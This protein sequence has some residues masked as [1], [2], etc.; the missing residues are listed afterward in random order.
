M[1]TRIPVSV[2]SLVLLGIVSLPAADWIRQ[3][4]ALELQAGDDVGANAV[5]AI[6]AGD[7]APWLRGRAL[8][9]LA[10]HAPDRIGKEL[11]A[12]ATSADPALR[13]A[14]A[15]ACVILGTRQARDLATDLLADKDEA[16]RYAAA[17][18]VAKHEG[19]GAWRALRPTVEKLIP[20]RAEIQGRILCAVGSSAAASRFDDFYTT[21][22]APVKRDLVRSLALAQ[23]ERWMLR[24]ERFL[25]DEDGAIRSVARTAALGLSDDAYAALLARCTQPSADSLHMTAMLLMLERPD[26]QGTAA[27]AR[28]LEIGIKD[29]NVARH[30]I[31]LLRVQV[32][33]SF[34]AVVE[35]YVVADDRLVRMSAVRLL[36]GFD[37]PERGLEIL[38]PAISD[39]H[40]DVVREAVRIIR[41]EFD[42]VPSGG[43]VPYVAPLLER[44]NT[45]FLLQG[46][47]L[48]RG[49]LSEE[50]ID[51]GIALLRPLLNSENKYVRAESRATLA[52][53]GQGGQSWRVAALTGFM[54]RW[55][56]IGP[57]ENDQENAGFR[58]SHP[59]EDRVDLTATYP[60][61][62]RWAAANMP[63]LSWSE[64]ITGSSG[65]LRL[66]NIFPPPVEFAT[67]Y[68]YTEFA[69]DMEREVVME[70][71][72]DDAVAVWLNGQRVITEGADSVAQ[73]MD[74]SRRDR[75][76]WWDGESKK[77]GS[78]YPA[79]TGKATVTL[80]QGR[81]TIL[82]K[83]SNLDIYWWL[84][85]RL[86]DQ[87][88]KAV[89][90]EW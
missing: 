42:A 53:A 35:R 81:N 37:D 56:V 28:L 86:M 10:R 90:V 72:A 75:R 5:A 66:H 21:A 77:R 45:D 33:Q 30:G 70:V 15:D 44:G 22:E 59:P 76:K 50:E 3:W 25:L 29:A 39:S 82:V 26:A 4:D 85:V 16:V 67:A 58:V 34:P 88:D 54:P 7:Q 83:C 14:A 65:Y 43:M 20:E 11:A 36:A 48:L 51:A 46:L 12:F 31:D 38:R 9:A 71:E 69:A 1:R 87:D 62:D 32:D 78:S 23:G 64:Q 49:R 19:D 6:V 13:L 27:I 79:V 57:W 63:S 40:I 47:R 89:E 73:N 80:Q 24:I 84:R 74:K 8:V 18:A 2:L 17:W 55:R 41:A 52:E 68:A 61:P 60:V